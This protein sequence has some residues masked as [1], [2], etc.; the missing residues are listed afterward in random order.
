LIIL[1]LLSISLSCNNSDLFQI[2]DF[3]SERTIKSEREIF[4]SGLIDSTIE[5]NLNTEL[6]SENENKWLKAFWA[7]QLIQYKS[8]TTES[9]IE[10]G[11]NKFE[12]TSSEFQRGLLEVSYSMYPS[13]FESQIEKLLVNIDDRKLYAMAVLYLIKADS[14]K[15]GAEMYLTEL[16]DKYYDWGYHP[17]SLMLYTQLDNIVNEVAEPLPPIED[18]L[19]MDLGSNTSVIY[20]FHRKNRNYNGISIIRKPDGNFVR[21]NDGSLFTVKQLARSITGLPYY[22]TN[23]NTPAGIY[24]VKEISNSDNVFI[25]P[26]PTL[27]TALPFEEEYLNFTTPI[28]KGDT[29]W[30]KN[31]TGKSS[32]LPG[33]TIF[34]STKAFL[35]A[36]QKGLK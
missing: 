30:I 16:K 15:E 35:P 25:G 4:K 10:N 23:G 28:S 3:I 33:I 9:A 21:K 14:S 22:I 19:L 13:Q 26:S 29:L 12:Q 24:K 8:E 7:M 32:R 20:S 5:S 2:D 34:Q 1:L 31:P 18:L 36:G 27:V 11:L 17:I 6:N